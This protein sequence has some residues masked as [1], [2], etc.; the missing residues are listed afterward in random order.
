M[1]P[2]S[3]AARMSL[4][5][6]LAPTQPSSCAFERR[7]PRMTGIWA[8]DLTDFTRRPVSNMSIQIDAAG[9]TAST[10]GSAPGLRASAMSSE[11]WY[12]IEQV[13]ARD[14]QNS[15][16]SGSRT[17]FS[18]PDRMANSGPDDEQAATIETASV[19]ASGR[20]NAV[21]FTKEPWTWRP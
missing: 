12:R 18:E 20:R 8:I 3:T 14:L 6:T 7:T 5:V 9:Q 10:F 11:P 21:T 2:L 13:A 17:S 1:R 15:C 19:A 4:L 16:T